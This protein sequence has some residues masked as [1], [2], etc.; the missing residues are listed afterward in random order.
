[1]KEGR[2]PLVP[3]GTVGHFDHYEQ[4]AALSGPQR[5]RL[6]VVVVDHD[7]DPIAL[8]SPRL[9]YARP[10]WLGSERGRGVPESMGWRP[11]ITFV[12]VTVDAMNAVHRV[13]G[14]FKSFGHDYRADT[15]RFVH[16]G[17]RLPA[18]TAE[19]MQAV[20]RVLRELERDRA[21]RLSSAKQAAGGGTRATGARWRR[22]LHQHHKAEPAAH[23]SLLAELM[24][25]P[26]AR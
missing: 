16:A 21:H 8:L 14:Q 26:E 7:D 22:S 19:Q 23:T 11:V 13:P 2:S 1:M 5:D 20:E 6:R 17:F 3:A 12:T 10:D 18:V 4:F 24:A 15:A 25:E 9:A